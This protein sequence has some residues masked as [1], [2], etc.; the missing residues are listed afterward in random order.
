MYCNFLL[1]GPMLY[2][3]YI[4]KYNHYANPAEINLSVCSICESVTTYTYTASSTITLN[5]KCLFTFNGILKENVNFMCL[6]LL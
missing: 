1:F 6:S 2:D 3:G 4:L 5:V